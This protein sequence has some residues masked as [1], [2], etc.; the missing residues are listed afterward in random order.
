MQSALPR[1]ETVRVQPDLDL[2]L[3]RWAGRPPGFVLVHGL[4]SNAQLWQG[5]AE[6][7]SDGGAGHA[8]TA[9]DLRGHGESDA[10]S[11]GYDTAT[12]AA[13]VVAASAGSASSDRSWPDSPGAEMSW[14]RSPPN[15]GGWRPA[16]P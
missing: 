6:A 14:L 9:I 3:L 13:D 15:I 12:A 4:A 2:R 8:V 11:S 16:L 1:S 5:V 7:L 10:S